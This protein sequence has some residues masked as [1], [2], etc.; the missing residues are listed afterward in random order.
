MTARS[1]DHCSED[2]QR[3]DSR[4]V[5]C[6]AGATAAAE[7]A[8]GTAFVVDDEPGICNVVSLHL[9]QLGFEVASF[10][11]AGE[12]L[13]ALERRHPDII[14]LDIALKGSDA[15]EVLRALGEQRY[16]GVVQ[17]MS[18]S[19]AG[20][21]E[22][23]RRVGAR[24]GLSMRPPLHK[25]FRAD[26][27]RRA[28]A[29]D[30][31]DG[32]RQ[33]TLVIAPKLALSLGEVLANGWLELWYQPKIDLD[34]RRLVGAEALARCRHPRHGVVAPAA[35]LQDAEGDHLTA[36][37]EV[38]VRAALADW[39]AFAACGANLR[40]AVNANVEA[41]TKLDLAAMVREQRPRHETWPGLIIEVPES[42]VVKD[43]SLLH[44]IATQLR[45][46]KITLSIDDFGEGFSSFARLRELQFRELKLDRSFVHGCS[47]DEKNRAICRAM[48][49]LARHFGVSAVAEGLEEEADV[50]ALRAMGCQMGQGY[51]F[52]RP[53][54]KSELLSL[55]GAPAPPDRQWSQ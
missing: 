55:L 53:M 16:S 30:P 44:E 11:S 27:I 45:I 47:G 17:L 10:H 29:A 22:D 14:F 7:V 28:V 8:A 2:R 33:A 36:L 9:T 32:Q 21:L 52:A 42:D 39:A 26:A 48:L 23:V 18:G 54:P 46:Y 24:H 38:A 12:A 20:L 19:D 49:D 50:D 4:D 1:L 34:G 25:P 31:L 6:D 35:F 15:V 5:R 3:A 51:F 13:A 37:T 43:V 40:L 41:L